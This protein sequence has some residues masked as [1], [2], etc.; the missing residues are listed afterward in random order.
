MTNA[1]YGLLNVTAHQRSCCRRFVD[2]R[3]QPSATQLSQPVPTQAN[4]NYKRWVLVV[5]SLSVYA[6]SILRV[7]TRL[8]KAVMVP[9][10]VISEWNETNDTGWSLASSKARSQPSGPLRPIFPW[11]E[12][13][14]VPS[15][16]LLPF[17]PFYL[18]S[19][20]PRYE[21]A[22]SIPRD[23]PCRPASRLAP[24]LNAARSRRLWAV[25]S[26][27]GLTFKYISSLVSDIHPP[28]KRRTSC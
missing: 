5:V 28:Y 19:L 9:E 26:A 8:L 11:G 23:S 3:A 7:S 27:S 14:L 18:L 6:G 22:V 12:S 25:R 16:P 17:H 21:Q 24:L 10:D 1:K 4:Y 13:C 15:S 20:F 2:D